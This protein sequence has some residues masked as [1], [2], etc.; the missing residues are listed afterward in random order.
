MPANWQVS[1]MPSHEAPQLAT[2]LWHAGRPWTGVVEIVLV[3]HFPEEL[4]IWQEPLQA[5]SQQT[6]N[7]QTLVPTHKWQPPALHSDRLQAVPALWLGTQSPAAS[8]K[9]PGGQPLSSLH[10]PAHCV[11]LRHGE[12]L[13][14]VTGVCAAQVPS[15]QTCVV[16]IPEAQ[17]LLPQL[18]PVLVQ[19]P[20]PLQLVCTH[21]PVMPAH[22]P[23]GSLPAITGLQVPVGAEH[24]MQPEHCDG[25]L[26]QQT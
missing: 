3:T 1:L 6:P 14:Q 20:R 5:F 2:P 23:C 24:C 17:L 11:P 8:Q 19:L 16:S 9:S 10:L 13:A 15:L 4:H 25:V 7:A 18:L 21:S 26:S 22:V 12:L